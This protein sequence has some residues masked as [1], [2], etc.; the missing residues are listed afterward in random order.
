MSRSGRRHYLTDV[1]VEGTSCDSAGP[2]GLTVTTHDGWS[3]R[4]TL[5]VGSNSSTLRLTERNLFGTGRE[6]SVSVKSDA[7]RVG[8]GAALRDPWFLGGPLALEVGTNSYRDGSEWYASVAR[9]ERSVFDLWGVEANAARAVRDPVRGVG[10]AF[11]RTTTSFLV[12]RRLWVSDAAVTA[13][14]G[15]AEYER[16]GL[17][18]AFDAAIIGPDRVRREFTGLDVG[19]LRRSVAYDT[20]T[21]LLRGK[22]LVDV[23]L[24][25]EVDALVGA[26]YERVSGEP[27]LH[28]D[29]WTGKMWLPGR[30]SVLTGDVWGSGYWHPGHWQAATLRAALSYFRSAPRGFWT[31]RLAGEQLFEPDPD[32]RALAS[33]DPTLEALP[34]RARLAKIAFAA[35]LERSL[36]LINPG[37]SYG[38]DAAIFSA[39][40]LRWDP[41][42]MSSEQLYVGVVGLGLRLAPAKPGRA[43]PRL[44]I[45]FPIVRSADVPR[46]AFIALT[47]SPWLQQGRWRDGRGS[48]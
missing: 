42:A 13:L 6:A 8:V 7:G 14:V 44:D 22:G 47:V 32:V 16:T 30:H 33:V 5:R 31:S 41:A 10:D 43:T 4:P 40:S 48:R 28:V 25:L 27:T 2:V 17:I 20:L 26:G 18:A 46:K 3:T 37:R 34:E 9:S 23:P 35:S 15:G 45:G 11:R 1:F 29:A 38:L 12:S 21:W 19:V 24:S 39:L 36:N